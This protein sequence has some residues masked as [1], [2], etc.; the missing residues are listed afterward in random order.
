MFAQID[1]KKSGLQRYLRLRR[2]VL[3]NPLSS[4]AVVIV[5]E[6]KVFTE[7]SE[8]APVLVD[9]GSFTLTDLTKPIPE[10][11]FDGKPTGRQ[12][13]PEAVALVFNSLYHA[14]RNQPDPMIKVLEE[15]RTFP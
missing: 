2:L 10:V 5:E 13:S 12:F 3:E 1:V 7:T 4:N 14:G 8:G 9:N 11:G 15:G 6:E